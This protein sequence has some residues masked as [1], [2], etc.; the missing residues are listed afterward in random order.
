MYFA[1]VFIIATMIS[2]IHQAER[3]PQP[4]PPINLPASLQPIETSPAISPSHP[5]SLYRSILLPDLPSL[6]F[7][8]NVQR[9]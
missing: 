7:L 5:L 6:L 1:I 3:K 8:C 2:T 9:L 4:Y